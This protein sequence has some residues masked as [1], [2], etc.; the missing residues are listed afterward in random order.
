VRILL[1]KENVF[2]LIFS[3]HMFITNKDIAE[4]KIVL[5]ENPDC[6]DLNL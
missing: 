6:V 4:V 5:A 3:L 2:N 1:I